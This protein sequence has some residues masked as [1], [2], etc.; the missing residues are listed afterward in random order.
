[1]LLSLASLVVLLGLSTLA[2]EQDAMPGIICCVSVFI[3]A[4]K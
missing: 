4:G 1:M 2:A 3:E